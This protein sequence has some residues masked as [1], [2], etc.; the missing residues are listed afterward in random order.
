MATHTKRPELCYPSVKCEFKSIRLIKDNCLGIISGISIIVGGG[1]TGKELIIVGL[2]F[3][4]VLLVGC[5]TTFGTGN[6][7]DLIQNPQ[8]YYNQTITIIGYPSPNLNTKFYSEL[9]YE[10]VER[11]EEGMPIGIMVKYNQFY[12]NKCEIT[13]IIKTIKT[14]ECQSDY[15]ATDRITP[16]T[17]CENP[18]EQLKLVYTNFYCKPN[19]ESDIY[20]L[21]VTKVKSLD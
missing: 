6:T 11:N 21:E 5:A 16:V 3:V 15:Y 19:S 18:P 9:K 14:C 12:C 20:Y 10:L 17:T 8:K 1:L 4:S 13:G 2:L 7:V